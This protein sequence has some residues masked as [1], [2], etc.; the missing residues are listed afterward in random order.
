MRTLSFALIFIALSIVPL[1]LVSAQGNEVSDL[2]GAMT[3]DL[4]LDQAIGAAIQ[5]SPSLQ[6][7]TYGIS[8]A[9]GRV[10]QAGL[11]PNPGFSLESEN[12]GGSGTLDGF[13]A[14]ETTAVISQE[15]VLGGKRKGRRAVAES[16]QR[17]A[18][19]DLEAARLDLVARTTSAYFRV[20]S[21]QER[22]VLAE[23]L[24]AL[25]D[26]FAR[27]VQARVDA[28]K[29]SPVEATRAGIEVA[30]ARVR[31]ARADRKLKATRTRL[32]ATWGSTTAVFDRAIGE[33][34]EPTP[35]PPLEQLRLLLS[36]T[37]EMGRLEEL[38]ERSEHMLEVEQ[39]FR[40]PNLTI[41]LGPRWFEET[42]QSAWVAGISLPI[43]I[44]NRN[45]GARN[46][47][48]FELKRTQRE[49]DAGKI[50]LETELAAGL[51]RLSAAQLE[52]ETMERE[53]VPAAEAAFR[54]T[55][56]GY[57]EG[58]FS[59][60]D[61]LDSQRALF[62]SRSLLLDSREEY[63]LTRTEIERLIGIGHDPTTAQTAGSQGE[64]S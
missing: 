8:A 51:Q 52:N 12:F 41:S 35:H 10:E 43:P 15:F 45:Q 64:D 29:V 2:S 13:N 6:A 3:G 1:S 63:A 31:H 14:A 37:P 20:V 39:S 34:P 53:V 42:G 59:F 54:A 61:V 38:I 28:G 17:L 58:K 27:T 4:T 62:E 16:E 48:E 33:L 55:E 32:A 5:R 7:A 26:R 44:F 47:A 21:A 30:Q 23:E 22:K 25:A 9:E 56:L 24:L 19:R 50:S 40:V 11:L 36:K 46:A 18:K 49:A 60:L 57:S